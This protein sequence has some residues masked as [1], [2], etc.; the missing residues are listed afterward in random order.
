MTSLW[1]R[2]HDERDRDALLEGRL[3]AYQNALKHILELADGHSHDHDAISE[4]AALMAI[5]DIAEETL[6]L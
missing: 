2:T 4:E 5:G 6:K 3:T 1:G